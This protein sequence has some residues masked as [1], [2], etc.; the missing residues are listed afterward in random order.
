[1]RMERHV[2]W[3]EG[4]AL[5]SVA[6]EQTDATVGEE[7]PR[8]APRGG[9]ARDQHSMVGKYIERHLPAAPPPSEPPP[10]PPL[11]VGT[12]AR[13]LPYLRW[14][15]WIL[16]TLFLLSFFW[17]FD[18]LTLRLLGGELA[19]PGLLRVVSVSGLI[20][21]ITNWLAVAMLFHPRHRRPIF[22]Q[23]LIPAQRERV[24][25]RLAKAVSE[26]LIS[27]EMIKEKI[28]QGGVVPKYCETAL[29]VTRS[30]VE[31]PE[32]RADLK[33]FTTDY[34]ATV[35]SSQE[36][37][38][39]ITELT[40]RNLEDSTRKSL[41]GLVL[42]AYRFVKEDDF[43]RHLD[44]AVQALPRSLNVVLDNMDGML[45]RLPQK[46]AEHPEEIQQWATKVVMGFVKDLDVYGLIIGNMQSY[47]EQKLET[48][49]K[50]SSN[51]QLDYIKSMGGVLGFVGGFVIW[52]PLLALAVFGALGL[53]LFALDVALLNAKARA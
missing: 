28:E 16:G 5:D 29:S 41:S 49:L 18:G 12:Q 37:R 14:I 10:E 24:I 45:D 31:D 25:F 34:I 6:T 15:P 44:Q 27:E 50:N 51:D 11:A 26:E 39:K 36:T 4:A 13:A 52:R 9:D 38:R 43:Q 47:D 32:F 8:Q 3:R 20:G 53:T 19:L 42:K 1:M 22:G 21:F 2:P 48:L 23:G 40:V 35:L 7:E 30:V 33:A 46:L 17:D